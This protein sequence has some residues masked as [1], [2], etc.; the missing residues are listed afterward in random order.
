MNTCEN[1]TMSTYE[2]VEK[3]LQLRMM[4][5]NEQIDEQTFKDTI[6]VLEQTPNEKI[7]S[8][9]YTIKKIKNEI[10]FYKNEEKELKKR[11]EQKEK[12]IERIEGLTIY[13]MNSLNINKFESAKA[14]IT[15]R[16]SKKVILNDDF[17]SLNINRDF[18]EK[19]EQ[20][21][22]D[23]K[24]VKELLK[25]EKLEGAYIEESRNIQIK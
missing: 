22:V 2:M 20:Y 10:E 1:V 4:V 19:T 17:I 23:K 3:I 25:T 5:G 24:R 9:A 14:K 11:R 16:N 13:L 21:K 18:I 12:D 15:F 6:E 7:E 8:L